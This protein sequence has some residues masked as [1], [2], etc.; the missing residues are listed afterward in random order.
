[1]MT[2]RRAQM[3]ALAGLTFAAAPALAAG[4]EFQVHGFY[5][6]DV[7]ILLALAGAFLKGPARAFLA[8]RHETARQEMDEA[9]SVKTD[10]EARLQKYEGAL[11]NLATEVTEL[12]ESFIQDGERE[13][14]RITQE[15][16]EAAEKLRRDA[17]ETLSREGTQLKK[18][19]E[20]SVATEA[21]ARAETMIQSRL[22]AQ[23]H[24]ALIETFI[25]DLE[26]RDEL[27]SFTG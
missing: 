16:E 9:M 3:A 25:T 22:D 5:I 23:T 20:R 24:K 26:S 11:A 1:M 13:A 14:I 17:A 15:G 21:L 10:S 4:F 12:N 2:P 27:G 6:I 19:I 7:V 8:N 18:D